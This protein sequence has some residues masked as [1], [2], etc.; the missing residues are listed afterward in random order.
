MEIDYDAHVEIPGNGPTPGVEGFVLVG[1]KSSRFGA[2]K[3]LHEIDGQPMALHVADALRVHSTAVTLVGKPETYGTL[4]LPVIPDA[5]PES[6]PLGGIVSALEHAKAPLCLIVAC[7]MPLVDSAPLGS[8]VAAA[9]R[10]GAGAMVPRTPDGRLQPLCAVYAK[11]ARAPLT[12]ALLN[13]ERRIVAALATIRWS[14]FPVGES[15]PFSN[16]NRVA[17]LGRR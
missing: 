10:T 6:G 4:G 17:D 15:L 2:D 12:S 1:G 11:W 8:L 5:F 14:P 3:A 7:D 9:A 16:V 13:G